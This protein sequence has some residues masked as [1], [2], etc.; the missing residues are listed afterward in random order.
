MA[1][2]RCGARQ[3]AEG[4]PPAAAAGGNRGGQDAERAN[5]DISA[6]AAEIE[7]ARRL[8]MRFEGQPVADAMA[9]RPASRPTNIVISEQAVELTD[10]PAF[11]RIAA[12]TGFQQLRAGIEGRVV[13][14]CRPRASWIA[15]VTSPAPVTTGRVLIANGPG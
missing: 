5:L 9:Q 6:D 11:D 1:R 10:R 4:R 15:M 3:Q 13:T 7:A 14:V 12:E 2:P 8:D